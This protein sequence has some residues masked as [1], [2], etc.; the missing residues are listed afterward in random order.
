MFSRPEIITPDEVFIYNAR[1]FALAP[2]R[3]AQELPKDLEPLRRDFVTT[4]SKEPPKWTGRREWASERQRKFVMAKLRREGNLPYRRTHQLSKGWRTTLKTS[5]DGGI[6]QAANGVLYRRFVQGLRAQ[7][8]HIQSGWVQ[9][10]AVV[11][12]FQK[13]ARFVARATWARVSIPALAR[14]R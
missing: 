1:T 2:V 13:Q 10:Q 14:I 8:M 4:I 7:R 3:M 6:L 9:E 5:R 12:T 11:P